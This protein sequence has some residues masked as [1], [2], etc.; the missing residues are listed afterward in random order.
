[1]FSS[2]Y[3]QMCAGMQVLN[4]EKCI[5][6]TLQIVLSLEPPAHE[7]IVVDGG[8]TDRSVIGIPSKAPRQW[9]IDSPVTVKVHLCSLLHTP[10]LHPIVATWPHLQLQEQSLIATQTQASPL[11]VC[12]AA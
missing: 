7:V 8:S 11:T 10:A 2:V 5:A 9:F 1:M 3:V 12:T 4:E 6:E